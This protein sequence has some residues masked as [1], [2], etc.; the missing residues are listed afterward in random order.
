[1]FAGVPAKPPNAGVPDQTGN[2]FMN[3]NATLFVQFVVFF[4]LAWFSAKFVWPMLIGAID[5]RRK[6]IAD[7]L[8]AAD[9]GKKSFATA[10]GEIAKLKDDAKAKSLEITGLADK[11]GTD[12]VAAAEAKAKSEADRIIAQAKAEA[13][14][15]VARAKEALREQVAVLAVKGAEK[16]LRREV[17]AKAHADMLN[18]LKTE[19]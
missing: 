15:E 10:Q 12:I 5:A 6:Q 19:L 4:V 17:D 8:A 11:R 9:E 13:A 16:I 2:T 18:Q 3:I 7:G 14:Q 1:M